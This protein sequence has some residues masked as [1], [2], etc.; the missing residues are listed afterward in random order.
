MDILDGQNPE[1]VNIIIVFQTEQESTVK[2]CYIHLE[3][4]PQYMNKKSF[5]KVDVKHEISS[6]E[7]KFNEIKIEK[8]DDL[9]DNIYKN[10]VSISLIFIFFIQVY[11]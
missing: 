9:N 11:C 8:H 4:L 6:E 5:V 1:S 2:E 10:E 3:R 7:N